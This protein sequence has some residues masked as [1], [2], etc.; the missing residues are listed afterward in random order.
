MT[1]ATADP[2]ATWPR[3]VYRS[4]LTDTDLYLGGTETLLASWEQYARGA[5]DAAVHRFMGVTTAVFPHEPE[6]SVYNNAVLERGLATAKRREAIDAME[7]VYQ[8]AGVTRYAAWVHESDGAMRS[9]L[10][11]RGYA[12]DEVTRAM[13][14][15]LDDIRLPRPKLELAPGDWSE[16]LPIAGV[17][18][19]LLSG[20]DTA[21]FHILVARLDGE[22]V[23]TAIAFDFDIDCGIYNVG[24]LEW[25]RRRGLATALTAVH[26]HDAIGRGC[27]T[28]SLQATAMAERLYAGVGF[29]DL[30]RILEFVPPPPEALDRSR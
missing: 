1:H 21:A 9:A 13:G 29:R 7:A 19:G 12:L 20:V 28:A 18:G 16:H 8:R 24:T 15:T 23:A 30:G 4:K 17:P 2:A 10:E 3:D 6:R 5:A 27:R 26:L 11:R 22:S 14:M 25:A